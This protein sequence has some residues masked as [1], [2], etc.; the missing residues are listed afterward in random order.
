[1]ALID[2]RYAPK[3][4]SV[5]SS[6]TT[7]DCHQSWLRILQAERRQAALC[8]DFP[9]RPPISCDRRVPIWCD[10]GHRWAEIRAAASRTKIKS[11]SGVRPMVRSGSRSRRAW[12]PSISHLPS[13]GVGLDATLRSQASCPLA[14]SAR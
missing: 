4:D 12:M 9:W 7:R 10:R 1:M 6:R 14:C 8:A 2:W 13:A 3:A 5:P 11:H